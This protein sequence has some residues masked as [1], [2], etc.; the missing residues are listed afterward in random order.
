MS[1]IIYEQFLIIC[2]VWTSTKLAKLH[3]ETLRDWFL[4][5]K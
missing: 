5:H 4:I 3:W 2:E 1:T